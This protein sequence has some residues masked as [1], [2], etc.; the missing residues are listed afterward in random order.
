MKN[1]KILIILFATLCLLSCKKSFLEVVPQGRKLATTTEDYAKMLNS[2]KLYFTPFAGWIPAVYMGDEVAAEASYFLNMNPIRERLFKWADTVEMGYA[3]ADVIQN[4]SG[5]GYSD[6]MYIANK[7]IKEVMSSDE[8]TQEQKTALRAEALA[9]RAWTLFNISNF[10][11]KPYNSATAATDMGMPFSTVADI[12]FK[13]F[14]RGTLRETYD[15]IVSDLTQAIELLPSRLSHPVRFNKAGAMGL[16]G[17]VY[18]YMGDYAK[19]LPL[20]ELTLT[21][22][23]SNGQ[24][25]YNYNQ[26]FQPD[27]TF[28]PTD[29]ISGPGGFPGQNFTDVRESVFSK[30]FANTAAHEGLILAPWAQALYQPSDLR[31]LLYTDQNPDFS[32]NAN[33]HVRKYATFYSRMGLQLPEVYLLIAE[34]KARLNDLS[35]AVSAL[36]NFRSNRMPS[37]DATVPLLIASNRTGLIK[38]I[39]DERVREFAMEGMRWFDMRRQSVDPLFAGIQFQ[40]LLFDDIG[41]ITEYTLNQPNRLVLKWPLLITSMSPN[42]PDNP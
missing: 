15:F 35:G 36:Q 12:T 32:P 42:L 24:S 39:F 19:A 17:K 38:F 30:I 8:G 26:T 7:I 31:L 6:M 21:E 14:K 34:C 2:P 37:A 20:L 33:G 3:G 5:L 27:G 1:L 4:P 16:L 22:S 18:V 29:P 23:L 28:Q 11:C 10:Y 9:T 40:H 13:D 25:L 41:S